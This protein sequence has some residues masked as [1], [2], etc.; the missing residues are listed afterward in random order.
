MCSGATLER[1]YREEVK[2][3]PQVLRLTREA[4]M[5]HEAAGITTA[6]FPKMVRLGGI[7]CAATYLHEPGDARDGLTVTVP[8][9]ALNQVAEARCEWLVPGMLKDKVQA[10][11]KSLPQRPRSRLVPLPE[12]AGAFC[13]DVPFGEGGLMEALVRWTRERTQLP[14]Q[15]HD[16][17]LEMLPAHQFMN[18]RL[19]D[20]H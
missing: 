14:L 11:L 5:R 10:L 3:Q 16:F 15:P 2:R 13:Q 8:L 6:A 18:L 17:K 9:V 1:W 7:D 12:A 4:L 20:E 19:V